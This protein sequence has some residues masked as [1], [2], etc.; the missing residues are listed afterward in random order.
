MQMQLQLHFLYVKSGVSACI[1]SLG[2]RVAEGHSMSLNMLSAVIG[3][4][5]TDTSSMFHHTSEM[6][7]AC[8][9]PLMNLL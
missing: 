6:K 3:F 1:S 4:H 9:H 5:A 7:C 2:S 8:M